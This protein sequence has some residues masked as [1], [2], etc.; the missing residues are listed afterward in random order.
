MTPTILL[1]LQAL[2]PKLAPEN[3]S[4]TSGAPGSSGALGFSPISRATVRRC[5]ARSEG[6]VCGAYSDLGGFGVGGND[7]AERTAQR[8]KALNWLSEELVCEPDIQCGWGWCPNLRGCAW[9]VR[10]GSWC[11]EG[12]RVFE[13]RRRRVDACAQRMIGSFRV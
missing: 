3:N 1:E 8:T 12:R 11:V 2:Q 7:I 10:V 4:P 13:A 9:L 5:F 6:S